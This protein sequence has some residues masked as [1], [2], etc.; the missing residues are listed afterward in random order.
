MKLPPITQDRNAI[1]KRLMLFAA[2]FVILYAV[3]LSL[4]PAVRLYS[5]KVPYRWEHW[6]GVLV[7]F[8]GFYILSHQLRRSIPAR[9]PI[10]L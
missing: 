5:W 1:E 3:I 7:W 10:L 8:V 2:G 4:S 9:D 6:L